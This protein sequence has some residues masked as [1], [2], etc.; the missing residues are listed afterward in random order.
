MDLRQRTSNTIK[1]TTVGLF[2]QVI[3]VFS[4]FLCRFVFV[5]V[6]T[7]SYLGVNE[8]FA[9]ILALLSLG[10]LGIGS[11]V[12]FEL[13]RSLANNDE[14]ETKALMNFYR[15]AY[16]IVG[17]VIGFIGFFLF[18]FINKLVSL[19]NT[20]HANIYMMYA[21]YLSDVVISYFFSY[22]SSIIEASQ[23]NYILSTIHA[24]VTIVQNILQC[25]ILITT[26]NYMLY[27]VIQV[28]C[29]ISYNVFVAHAADRLFPILKD[30][31]IREVKPDNQKRMYRNIRDIFIENIA[32]KLMNS[33]DNIII[34][35]VGGLASTGLNSNYSLLY[36]TLVTFTT[37]IQLG[38]ASSVGNVNAVESKE[39]R[40]QLF[41]EIHFS[42]FWM[43][44]WCA[45]CYILLVQDV[46]SLFFGPRYLMSFAVA[47]ITGLNFYIA[48]EGT[49]VTIFKST[50][51]LFS[52]GKLVAVFT[53]IINIILSILLGREYGVFGI[54]LAT[55]I[56]RIVTVRWYMPYVTFKYGFHASSKRYF[57]DEL[58]Y[59]LEGIFIFLITYYICT[60]LQMAGV[61]LLFIKAI[62]CLFVPNMLIIVLHY[63]DPY[64]LVLKE[65]IVRTVSSILKKY[66]SKN[67]DSEDLKND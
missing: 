44:F 45:C 64:F 11:A 27:L 39:K 7:E 14:E 34:T 17:V 47:V 8:L 9:N 58:R 16:S 37:K 54:L 35:A 3:Q 10:S 55:F 33:T 48:E 61:L 43:Y 41:D 30:K 63:R 6:L 36:A 29:S 20:I 40:L 50:M 19:D 67:K 12:T 25:I 1:N 31:N 18:P 4:S 57:L 38:I 46:I 51:G 24:A 2:T 21:L 23:Q 28:F 62:I 5:H 22:K 60:R 56:S 66:G 15:K 52:K 26:R 53:G 65:R 32:G 42:F 49:V 59:W 13:Y